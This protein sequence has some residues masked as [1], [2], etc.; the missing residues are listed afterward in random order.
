MGITIGDLVREKLG[1]A[2]NQLIERNLRNKLVN[3]ALTSTKTIEQTN[4]RT[5]AMQRRLRLVEQLGPQES[6]TLLRRRGSA[7][8]SAKF[9][10][11]G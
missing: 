2:R 6:A 10:G 3:C 1:H 7:E 9:V 11:T 5:N 4:T 8:A